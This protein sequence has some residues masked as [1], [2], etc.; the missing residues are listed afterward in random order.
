MVDDLGEGRGADLAV[1]RGRRDVADD[2]DAVR[3]DELL[4]DRAVGRDDHALDL[5]AA[6]QRGE[7]VLGQGAGEVFARRAG[8][9]AVEAGLPAR[10]A[11]Y[12]DDR[13][14]A[15]HASSSAKAS[16][17][18]ASRALSARVFI[19]VSAPRTRAPVTVPSSPRS[20]TMPRRRGP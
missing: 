20:T 5:G 15:V 14:D 1:G 3:Q 9:H 18:R 12:G 2:V 16:T 4:D 6:G 13:P 7:D 11:L 19:T 10:E 17:S 8:E